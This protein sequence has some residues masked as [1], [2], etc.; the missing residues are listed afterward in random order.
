MAL[1]VTP[2]QLSTSR[3]LLSFRM[4][5]SPR[6]NVVRTWIEKANNYDFPGAQPLFTPDFLLHVEPKQASVYFGLDYTDGGLKYK[7]FTPR[8]MNKFT[9]QKVSPSLLHFKLNL[10]VANL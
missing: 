3:S 1:G 6:A 2:S 9:S 5:E 4:S 7:E 8:L 10:T